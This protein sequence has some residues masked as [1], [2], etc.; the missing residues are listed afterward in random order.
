MCH[1]LEAENLD[2]SIFGL[3][4]SGI[5]VPTV[6]HQM[7]FVPDPLPPKLAMTDAIGIALEAAMLNVGQLR[8]ISEFIQ[9][10]ELVSRPLLTREAVFSS[11]IEG[12]NASVEDV[13]L[14][15]ARVQGAEN[16]PDSWEVVHYL[17]AINFGIRRVSEE[18]V[19]L[20]LIRDLHRILMTGTFSRGRFKTPGEFRTSQNWIGRSTST[21]LTGARYIPPPPA[22]MANALDDLDRYLNAESSIPWL[23]RLALVHYQFEA[24]HP[25]IDGNGRVG[26]MLVTLLLARWQLLPQ[27]VLHL[28]TYLEKNRTEYVD[29]LLKVSTESA[30]EEWLVFFLHGVAEQAREAALR[31]RALWNLREEYM[32]RVRVPQASGL[33]PG[34]VD[35]LF[36][37]QVITIP[38]A[39]NQMQI[40]Y[41]AARRNIDR[42]V[43]AGILKDIGL[44][45]RRNSRL[46]IALEILQVADAPDT[47]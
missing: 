45:G 22:N 14:A 33:L 7:A 31:V 46:F 25:F 35:S 34:L 15:D 17:E 13:A 30:W 26:R 36:E 11:R 39:A 8:G 40:T 1:L 43:K 19:N 3:E 27:P 6:E 5:L 37:R 16:R 29:L 4:S 23:V 18:P 12:I 41:T 32:S 10:P 44:G 38:Q 20:D 47:A 24:I 28:S 21:P 2:V 9:V 42:L